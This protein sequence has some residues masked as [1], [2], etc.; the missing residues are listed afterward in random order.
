MCIWT[1]PYYITVE[2]AA[3]ADQI[4]KKKKGGTIVGWPVLFVLLLQGEK[5]F[6]STN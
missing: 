2:H 5:L 3:Q 1:S 6:L 4:S